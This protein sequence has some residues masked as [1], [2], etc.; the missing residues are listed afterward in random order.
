MKVTIDIPDQTAALLQQKAAAD[1]A[2]LEEWLEKVLQFQ[3]TAKPFKSS[4]GLLAKYGPG[5]S[6][7]DI[8]EVRAEMLRNF[9]RDIE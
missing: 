3:A 8:A 5:P 4:Y 2:T 7:E 9:P 6:E 1:G